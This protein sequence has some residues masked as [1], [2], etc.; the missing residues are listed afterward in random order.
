MAKELEVVVVSA[1]SL[2]L[3]DKDEKVDPMVVLEFQ[4]RLLNFNKMK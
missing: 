4:G 3:V 2:K 1:S